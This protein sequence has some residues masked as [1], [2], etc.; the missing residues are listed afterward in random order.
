MRYRDKSTGRT[1]D[2]R[3]SA[4]AFIVVARPTDAEGLQAIFSQPV[5]SVSQSSEKDGVFLLEVK[6]DAESLA[7]VNRIVESLSK[8]DSIVAVAPALIDN[9]QHTRYALPGRVIVQF[10]GAT[11]EQVREFA[12]S[13]SSTT[14]Q[15]FR[16]PG[17]YE[18]AVPPEQ[19]ISSFI[20]TLNASAMVAYAEPSFYGFNDLEWQFTATLTDGTPGETPPGDGTTPDEP[21]TPNGTNSPTEPSSPTDP[22]SPASPI[23]ATPGWNLN[24]IH[25]SKAWEHTIGTA[26][27]V[28]FVVDG[29]P[30]VQH[31]CIAS[32]VASAVTDELIFCTERD[33]SSHATN[34]ASIVAGNSGALAGV[35]P[36]ARMLPL[37]VNLRSQLYAERA[38]ALWAAASIASNRQFGDFRF[39]RAVMC[40]SWKTSGDI[41]SIRTTLEDAVEAGIVIVTSAGNEAN[42]SPHYPSDYASLPGSLGDGLISVAATDENDLKSMYSNYSPTVSICAPGG[43]GLPIDGGDVR[44]AELGNTYGRAAGTSISAPHVAAVAALMLSVNPT[45]PP[46]ALKQ[47]IVSTADSIS[48]LN[49]AYHSQLGAGRVNALR[50]VLAAKQAM[51]HEEGSS[52]TAP[53]S[54][55]PGVPIAEE[56]ADEQPGSSHGGSGFRFKAWVSRR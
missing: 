6:S 32:Q 28:V 14:L 26:N 44:C 33:S 17:S 38:D 4:N 11:D 2:L 7:E 23:S 50:A 39:E 5:F 1:V 52:E 49:P 41:A 15:K 35:A 51:E 31:E 25:A 24:R 55:M 20:D 10:A 47:M 16:R 8:N 27:V 46:R 48:A 22:A 40:C 42:S 56:P 3:G 13:V 18:L 30:E 54:E 53:G 12:A 45:L 9:E 21:S 37:V 29:M 34:I 36:G 43:N 19:D